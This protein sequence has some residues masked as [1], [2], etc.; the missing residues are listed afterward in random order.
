MSLTFPSNARTRVRIV[1]QSAAHRLKGFEFQ[2]FV[3]GKWVRYSNA[4]GVLASPNTP[5]KRVEWIR[6]VKHQGPPFTDGGPLLCVKS[7][8]DDDVVTG[9]GTF[10]SGSD[11]FSTSQGVGPTRYV[12]GFTTPVMSSFDPFNS[13]YG[14]LNSLT[15]NP[16][17]VVP[18]ES[19]YPLVSKMRPRISEAD[20]AV[21]IGELRDFPR[22]YKDLAEKFRFDW[23]LSGNPRP[24][25]GRSMPL[26]GASND[27]LAVQFGWRPFLSSLQKLYQTTQNASTLIKSLIQRNAKWDKRVRVFIEDEQT[28]QLITG[29]GM[30][31]SPSGSDVDNLCFVDGSGRR[32]YWSATKR[33]QR[34]VWCSGQF[35]FYR[36]EFD[37]SLSGFD[38]NWNYV[39]QLITLYGARVN[40]S[41]IYRLTPWTWLIDWFANVGSIIEQ[42]SLAANDAVVSK[43]LYL[44]HRQEIVIDLQQVINFK[45]GVRTLNFSRILDVKQRDHAVT[46]FGFG[47]QPNSLSG[48]QYAILAALGISRFR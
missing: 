31:V 13:L 17:V 11:T 14:N 42:L 10:T 16:T 35:R 41:V 36:P 5:Y 15:S 6:D 3:G 7:N 12:G 24:S 25:R 30:K 45:D 23:I 38:S 9:N 32:Q 21:D 39:Q 48:M 34:R 40:P 46:P 44:M 37:P 2:V 18:L 19:F 1:P 29:N 33:T 28:E 27:F 8:I 47:L 4:L 20:L 22:M 26:S 43:E